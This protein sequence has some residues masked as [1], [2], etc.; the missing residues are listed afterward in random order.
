MQRDQEFP[1]LFFCVK[2]LNITRLLKIF[3][4]LLLR[5]LE[6]FQIIFAEQKRE[7]EVIP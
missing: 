7:K 3:G 4:F 5:Y 1:G 6:E 2:M